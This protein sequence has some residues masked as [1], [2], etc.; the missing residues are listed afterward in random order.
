MKQR[1]LVIKEVIGQRNELAF[2]LVEP[3]IK[4]RLKEGSFVNVYETVNTVL[5]S[6][7]EEDEIWQAEIIQKEIDLMFN[8]NSYD[9]IV[10]VPQDAVKSSDILVYDPETLDKNMIFYNIGNMQVREQYE[11]NEYKQD[12]TSTGGVTQENEKVTV[13]NIAEYKGLWTFVAIIPWLIFLLMYLFGYKNISGIPFVIAAVSLG[14]K[15]IRNRNLKDYTAESINLALFTL[16]LFSNYQNYSWIA[17]ISPVM[18]FMGM[19]LVFLI[20]K[21]DWEDI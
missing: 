14:I 15:V 3:Y 12:E 10:Y 1:I 4:E 17:N 16:L 8:I 19:G 9:K 5:R 18:A 13:K 20:S 11:I 7:L 21:I 2:S 6:L